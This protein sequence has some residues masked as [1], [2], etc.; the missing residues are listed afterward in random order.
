M[1]KGWHLTVVVMAMAFLIGFNIVGIMPVL[2]MIADKYPDRS[3]GTIQLLQTI[4][5]ALLIVGSL[6]VGFLSSRFSEKKVVLTGT[7]IIGVSGIL[8]FFVE[9]FTL[10]FACRILIGL[11]VG[12][13]SPMITAVITKF[14]VPEKRAGYMGLNVVA[15]GI[16][17]MA[18]NLIGGMLAKNGLRYFFLIYL[19]VAVCAVLI[20]LYL[21]DT[22]PAT[23]QAKSAA[24]SYKPIV[25]ALST[26][27][28]VHAVFITAYSTNIS[29]F[30]SAHLTSDPGASGIATAVNALC[31]MILGMFFSKV[32]NFLKRTSLPSSALMAAL[33]FGAILLIPGMPGILICSGLCGMSLSCFSAAGAYMVSVSVAQE[34]VAGASG[35]YNVFNSIG[36]LIAPFILGGAATAMGSNT[37]DHQFTAAFV[38]ML[39]LGLGISAF[40]FSR[41]MP[42]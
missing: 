28:L 14:S 25:F 36:G 33:G 26:M 17:G 11:G 39:A 1:K 10:L 27:T 42:E 24:G 9:N 21:P 31:A 16:S 29:L 34:D 40:I 22:A 3:T 20:I 41:P 37:P 5:Y 35:I 23:S 6:S 18:G 32:L 7:L 38:G 12:I 13:I 4:H 30:I 15:M 2:S 19:L 8:P